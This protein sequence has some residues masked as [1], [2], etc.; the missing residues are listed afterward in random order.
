MKRIRHTIAPKDARVGYSQNEDRKKALGEFYHFAANATAVR[1]AFGYLSSPSARGYEDNERSTRDLG[2]CYNS[3]KSSFA[4]ADYQGKSRVF[5]TDKGAEILKQSHRSPGQY[6]P[7]GAPPLQKRL[8]SYTP[9]ISYD[10]LL[11]WL[12]EFT[13]EKCETLIIDQCTRM[14]LY[15]LFMRGPNT[16]EKEYCKKKLDL[17]DELIRIDIESRRSM[18]EQ[19]AEEKRIA[20]DLAAKERAAKRATATAT[21]AAPAPA[22]KLPS[23]GK[24]DYQAKNKAIQAPGKPPSLSPLAALH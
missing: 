9:L 4:A 16:D 20:T 15:W 3:D 5:V 11:A 24:P 8:F 7:P 22:V 23:I 13:E 21:A 10:N 12:V 17:F 1:I 14:P 2:A 18:F 19:Q 6:V